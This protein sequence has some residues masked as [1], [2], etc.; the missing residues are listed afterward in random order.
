[1]LARMNNDGGEEGVSWEGFCEG[2]RLQTT[3]RDLRGG[4]LVMYVGF[5]CEGVN[6]PVGA[7]VGL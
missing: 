1:M 5:Q 4:V 2:Y 6:D 3:P 7:S